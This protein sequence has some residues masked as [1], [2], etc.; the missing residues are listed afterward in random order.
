[1]IKNYK[2]T[3]GIQIDDVKGTYIEG[4]WI[5]K[6]LEGGHKPNIFFLAGDL[7]I[8]VKHI[9]T[10][11]ELVEEVRLSKISKFLVEVEKELNETE[12]TDQKYIEELGGI[13]LDD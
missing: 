12:I 4:Y 2:L 13:V 3:F 5:E 7:N 8:A 6:T 1:M 9:Q 11:N 10:T